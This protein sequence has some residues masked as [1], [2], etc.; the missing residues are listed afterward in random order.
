M[1]STKR[2]ISGTWGQLWLN[3]DLVG[4]CTKFQAKMSYNKEDVPQC[5][6]MGVGTKVTSWKG[7]GSIT[8]NHVFSRMVKIIGEQIINGKDARFTVISKLADPD[9]YGAERVSISDVSFDDLTLADWEATK[10]GKVECPFTF[11]ETP[12]FLD[13]IEVR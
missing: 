9:A 7:T 6:K 5:G 13:V 10:S 3:G 1:D 2:V 8:L 4:E 12:V 11:S